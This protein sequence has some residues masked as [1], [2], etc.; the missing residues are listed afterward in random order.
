ME[1]DDAAWSKV[2]R[3]PAQHVRSIGLEQEHVATDNG[4]EGFVE[5]QL[6]RIAFAKRN[7]GEQ[8]RFG[9]PPCGRNRSG[10][11]I[12]ADHRAAFTYDVRRKEGDIATAAADVEHPHPVRET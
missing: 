7:M 3:Q 5:A 8:S 2:T 4:V 10:C 12:D 6:G 11:A 9:A 1:C